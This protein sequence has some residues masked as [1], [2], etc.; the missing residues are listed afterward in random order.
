MKTRRIAATQALFAAALMAAGLFA[1]SAK[2]QSMVPESAFQGNFTLP[3]AVHWGITVIPAGSYEISVLNETQPVLS[4]RDAKSRR[5][6]ALEP[7][8]DRDD[9]G[10]GGSALIISSH[11]NQHVVCSLTL[12]EVGETLVYTRSHPRAVEEARKTQSI[13]VLIAKK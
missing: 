9:A 13:P 5:L 4:I 7:M 3:Y 2:A 11:G 10:T 8:S 1:G 12:A 6:V